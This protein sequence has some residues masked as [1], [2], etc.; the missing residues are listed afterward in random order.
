MQLHVPELGV[1]EQLAVDEQRRADAGAEGQHDDRALHAAAR[2][3]AHLGEAGRIGIV[4]EQRTGAPQRAA[5]ER[6]AVRADPGLIDV[7]GGACPPCLTTVGK[8]EPDRGRS[9][10]AAAP[11]AAA[12]VGIIASGVEGCGVG[13]EMSSPDQAPGSTSTSARL[14]GGAPDIDPEQSVVS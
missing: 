6:R 1:G 9:P 5:D 3:Q 8:G 11:R 12:M 2:A 14:D 4:E 10:P 13:A 7:G